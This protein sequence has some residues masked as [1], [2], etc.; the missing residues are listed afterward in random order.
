VQFDEPELIVTVV[1]ELV[2]REKLGAG[3]KD[4]KDVQLLA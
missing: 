2:E 4:G 1:R 3:K